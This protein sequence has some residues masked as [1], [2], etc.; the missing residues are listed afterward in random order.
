MTGPLIVLGATAVLLG[1]FPD[2]VTSGLVSQIS[3]MIK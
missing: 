1:V 2:L 3:T